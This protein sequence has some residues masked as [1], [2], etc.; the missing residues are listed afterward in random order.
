MNDIEA[1]VTRVAISIVPL[2][3]DIAYPFVVASTL[4][5]AAFCPRAAP[6]SIVVVPPAFY[7][8]PRPIPTGLEGEAEG[9]EG[10]GA[11]PEIQ[12]DCEFKPS[13]SGHL[14]AFDFRASGLEGE[15]DLSTTM[16]I[17]RL[18]GG[19][20]PHSLARP[21]HNCNSIQRARAPPTLIHPIT[22]EKV[23]FFDSLKS[24]HL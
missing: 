3:L 1:L 5:A 18:R 23:S 16:Q 14:Q 10:D 6:F 22:R 7:S 19:G 2:T 20:M 9:G 15:A 13:L 12:S 21:I 4:A 8:L 11:D 17:L 24:N